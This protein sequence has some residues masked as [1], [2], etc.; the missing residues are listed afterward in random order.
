MKTHFAP[1]QIKYTGDQLRS[2]WAYRMF[3]V[4]G[5]SIVAFI[6]PCEV[7]LEKMVD[8][9][10]VLAGDSI[11]SESMLHFIA[12]HF[13]MDLEK[14]VLRQRLFIALARDLLAEKT[15]AAIV[16]KGDDLYEG[17][18]KISVSIATLSPVSSL[19]HTGIN[20]SSRNTPVQT[21]GLDNYGIDPTDFGKRLLER[22]R[23]EC[24]GVAMA[25][26]KV[27]GVG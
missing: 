6:G 24:E 13:E 22:Y 25:R 17:L 14:M 20:I 3:G 21:K 27:R 26:C 11:Y 18:S 23:E 12:E 9:A 1:E 4:Q 15:G 10:D 8:M 5:D 19:M 2:L 16:R 7:S